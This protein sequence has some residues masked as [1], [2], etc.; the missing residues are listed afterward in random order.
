MHT[1]LLIAS[2]IWTEMRMGVRGRAVERLT[3]CRIYHVVLVANV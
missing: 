2:I 3:A 1:T